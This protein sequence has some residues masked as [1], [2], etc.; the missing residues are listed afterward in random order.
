MSTQT[1]SPA[2]SFEALAAERLA[3]A[4]RIR[5]RAEELGEGLEPLRAAMRRRACELELAGTALREIALGQHV[6]AA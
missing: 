4:E 5:R 6:A 3:R 1:T 2:L